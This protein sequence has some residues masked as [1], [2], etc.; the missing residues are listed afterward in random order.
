MT[1]PEI[2]DAWAKES[3]ADSDAI[4]AGLL[5]AFWMGEFG[6][7]G[8]ILPGGKHRYEDG[9]EGPR[10]FREDTTWARSDMLEALTIIESA[11]QSL[12]S[13]F[14]PSGPRFNAEQKYQALATL[15]WSDYEELDI[16]G[17]FRAAYIGRCPGDN[18]SSAYEGP[19]LPRETFI[20]WCATRGYREPVF[21]GSEAQVAASTKHAQEDDA[22][23][24]GGTKATRVGKRGRK[25]PRYYPA[26]EKFL[27]LH[28]KHSGP[29][30]FGRRGWNT[31][32]TEFRDYVRQKDEKGILDFIPPA[33][34]RS[35]TFEGHA[36]RLL[37][38][39]LAEKKE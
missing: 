13:K 21:W 15:S 22:V 12:T 18:I 20:K 14:N 26:L 33:T 10:H 6:E 29:E 8:M 35:T 28:I 11:E 24:S 38:K 17:I 32:R 5:A 16:D 36:N 23:S 31:V 25:R 1:L 7:D 4:L 39:I 30:Y 27:T 2:A 9:P 3:E 37:D 19:V 34:K